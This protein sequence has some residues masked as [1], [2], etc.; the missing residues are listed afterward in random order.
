MFEQ[1][2]LQINPNDWAPRIITLLAIPAIWIAINWL[3]LKPANK[4]AEKTENLWDNA[5][6]ASIKKPLQVLVWIIG[7]GVLAELL[8]D[9]FTDPHYLRYVN[10][11]R[12]IAILAAITWF[13]HLF[14]DQVRRTYIATKQKKGLDVDVAM[15]ESMARLIKLAIVII[16]VLALLQYLGISIAGV[17]TFG[18]VGGIAIGFAAKDLLSNFFGGLMVY[19]DRPFS[20]G[21]WI[22]SPDRDIA[23]TVEKIGWR[24]TVI[25]RFDSEPL[26][27]PNSIFSTIAIKNGTRRINRQIYETIGIRYDDAAVMEVIVSD[28]KAYLKQHPGIDHSQEPV[29]NFT[30]FAPSSL[31][32][33]IYCFADTQSW[34]V[35]H[36]TK[37]QV[38]LGILKIIDD[39][40][41][42]CAFPTS[43]LYLKSD[44]ENENTAPEEVVTPSTSKG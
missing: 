11:V 36:D 16:A 14:V 1:W 15:V 12:D 38:M 33:F 2:I 34:G 8:R 4:R 28:V 44:S 24:I 3:I 25:R 35:F 42:E 43:T 41:A 10:V 6:L 21:E 18:G 30:S 17:L 19:F 39:H 23:G 26:Y 40:G 20:I 37:Q 5:L 31:D 27:V 22:S 29:V 13:L 9:E 32:F 7:L